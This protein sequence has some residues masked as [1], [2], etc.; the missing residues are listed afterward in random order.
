MEQVSK[1]KKPLTTQVEGQDEIWMIYKGKGS[2]Q[3]RGSRKKK[4]KR[5][6]ESIV[7]QEQVLTYTSA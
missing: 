7:V 3:E 5:E 6:S 1:K 4:Q 2:L